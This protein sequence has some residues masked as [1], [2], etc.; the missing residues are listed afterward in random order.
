MAVSKEKKGII[1]SVRDHLCPAESWLLISLCA[2]EI[3]N[4]ELIKHAYLSEKIS[5]FEIKIEDRN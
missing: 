5:M 3:Q 1:H 4:R 2:K